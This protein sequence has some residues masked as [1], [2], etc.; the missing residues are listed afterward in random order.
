MYPN[1][2]KKNR[3][4]TTCNWL[5]LETLGSQPIMPKKFPGLCA[6]LNSTQNMIFSVRYTKCEH[7]TNTT[8]PM[9]VSNVKM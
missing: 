9:K 6:H 3:E 1:S 8:N 2:M 7:Y 4:I 5:V